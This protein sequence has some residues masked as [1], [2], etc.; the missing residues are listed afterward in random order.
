MKPSPTSKHTIKLK[1]KKKKTKKINTRHPNRKWNE[2]YQ[3]KWNK[4]QK[5]DIDQLQEQRKDFLNNF[6]PT[7]YW[8]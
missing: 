1:K 3:T 6:N 7:S 8:N 4:L 2:S 5:V